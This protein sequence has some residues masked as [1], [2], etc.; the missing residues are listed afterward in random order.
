MRS[1]SNY[2][3]RK[4]TGLTTAIRDIQKLVSNSSCFTSDGCEVMKQESNTGN[5]KETVV[6]LIA[7]AINF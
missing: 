7:L 3:K 2:S 1:N 6:G 5:K 4:R